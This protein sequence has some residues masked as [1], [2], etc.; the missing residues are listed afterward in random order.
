MGDSILSLFINVKRNSN[1]EI[2][3]DKDSSS[4]QLVDY[5]ISVFRN[6]LGSTMIAYK[7]KGA[8]KV[9][10]DPRD[11]VIVGENGIPLIDHTNPVVQEFIRFLKEKPH[12][13]DARALT[14]ASFF[15]THKFSVPEHINYKT[16]R[17]WSG[18]NSSRYDNYEHYVFE[19]VAQ[20]SVAEEVDP[21]EPR[22]I[23][24][25]L[26]LSPYQKSESV[27]AKE[28]TV[29]KVKSVSQEST[30][31]NKNIT[32]TGSLSKVI[33]AGANYYVE[34]STSFLEKI[35]ATGYNQPNIGSYETFQE[36]NGKSVFIFARTPEYD[37]NYATPVYRAQV[38][39]ESGVISQVVLNPLLAQADLPTSLSSAEVAELQDYA[40]SVPSSSPAILAELV[41]NFL[42]NKGY[43]LEVPNSYTP[44]PGE[45]T[46]YGSAVFVV[47]SPTHTSTL[48]DYSKEIADDTKTISCK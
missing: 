12:N 31:E 47:D 16:R 25:Y 7:P 36:L 42:N 15:G 44:T 37:P 43:I 48:S 13:I 3:T 10:I 17:V 19:E 18:K 22:L 6:E 40:S 34:H 20:V 8:E 24:R 21:N 28:A 4:R 41:M 30:Q 14:P 33:T 9:I 1:S 23:N 2:E 26:K 27:S 35:R 45:A 46:I 29:S 39:F 38:S 11:L 32:T 5:E